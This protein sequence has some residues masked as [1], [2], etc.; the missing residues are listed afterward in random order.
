MFVL[1]VRAFF[2]VDER[3]YPEV[4][5]TECARFASVSVDLFLFLIY[6]TLIYTF[7]VVY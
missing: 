2:L 5:H 3:Q 7:V 6:F 4:L 1:F